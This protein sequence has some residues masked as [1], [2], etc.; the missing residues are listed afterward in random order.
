MKI[1]LLWTTVLAA[2]IA[3]LACND[4]SSVPPDN[5]IGS[6]DVVT[7]NRQ[8]SGFARDRVHRK[9]DSERNGIRH[10]SGTSPLGVHL[11]ILKPAL[12]L[13]FIG[14]TKTCQIRSI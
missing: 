12:M 7:E 13:G 10:G 9:S 5:I 1:Q 8:E 6:G 11:N 4:S 3:A 14:R 2:M